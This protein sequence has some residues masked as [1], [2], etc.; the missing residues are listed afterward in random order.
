MD[1][2]LYI[3]ANRSFS[4]FPETYVQSTTSTACSCATRQNPQYSI[5]VARFLQDF[6]SEGAVFVIFAASSCSDNALR[7]LHYSSAAARF[8][9]RNL[10][11]SEPWFLGT[12]RPRYLL[13]LLL[14]LAPLT[15]PAS[16]AIPLSSLL[17]QVR[18]QREC[19]LASY[20]EAAIEIETQLQDLVSAYQ[21]AS[22]TV[23]IALS[24][25]TFGISWRKIRF[26]ATSLAAMPPCLQAQQPLSPTSP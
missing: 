5:W 12:C 2:P 15:S 24:L 11:A 8:N 16:R 4:C 18:K 9:N 22:T 6:T 10:V 19:L 7:M 14:E 13:E 21:K 3:C 26:C 1:R 23:L 20:S 25:T 17:L